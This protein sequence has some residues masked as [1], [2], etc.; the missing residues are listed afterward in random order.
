MGLVHGVRELE[1]GAPLEVH[2]DPV[3]VYVFGE[4]GALVAPAAYATAA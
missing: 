4:D 3:H 2:L 1:I